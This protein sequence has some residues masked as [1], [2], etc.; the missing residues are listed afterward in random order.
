MSDPR[1]SLEAVYPHV[2][3]FSEISRDHLSM[4]LLTGHAAAAMLSY[5]TIGMVRTGR[6]VGDL[7]VDLVFS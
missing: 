3:G 1:G 7:A 4:D 5:P 6:E 2:L